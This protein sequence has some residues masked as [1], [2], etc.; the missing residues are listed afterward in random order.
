MEGGRGSR[1]L[2]LLWW[3][4]LER[5]RDTRLGRAYNDEGGGE[6]GAGGREGAQLTPEEKA[7]VAA[8][9]LQVGDA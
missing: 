8:D 5:C 4:R 6:G 2:L 1:T 9:E 3:L 7:I